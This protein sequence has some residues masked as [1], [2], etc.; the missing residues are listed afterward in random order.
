MNNFYQRRARTRI[1]FLAVL[2]LL[3]SGI[4]IL[5][6]IDLQ[7]FKHDLM[8]KRAI[9]QNQRI[10]K[11]IP[12][13]GFIY[14]RKGRILASSV[15]KDSIYFI[16][17]DGE[18]KAR[19]LR[20]IDMINQ[21]IRL[22][23]SE[24][25]KIRERINKGKSFIWIKRKVEEEK[26]R[27]VKRLNINGVYF[28]K[29]YRRFYPQRNLAS[30]VLGGVNIDEHGLNG[31]EKQYDIQLFGKE[32]T[33]LFLIDAKRRRY[34]LKILKKPIP[35]K[36][37]MLTI[38]E[39]IQ[40]IAEKELENT[41]KKFEA[42][43]GWLIIMNPWTGEILAMANYPSYDPNSYP[44]NPSLERNNSIAYIY[45]PGSTF[46]II[47]VAAAL[48]EDIVNERDVFDCEN[49]RIFLAG[50]K[51]EDYK[52]FSLLTLPEI[53]YY[54]SNVGAIKVGLRLGKEKLYKYLKSFGFGE[55]TGIDLPGEENGILRDIR[56]WSSISVGEISIGYEIGV[57]AI[58][59]LRAVSAIA[60]GGYL[61]TPRIVKKIIS[62]N[63]EESI[64]LI[65]P[66]KILIKD[67]A[68]KMT[69]FMEGVVEFGTGK[70]AKIIGYKI[71][72]K[73]GTTQK[74][75]DLK[76]YSSDSHI[77]SFV[78]FVPADEPVFSMIV[79]INEPKGEY[80][81][82]EVAAPCFREVAK[83]ILRY[84]KIF[85]KNDGRKILKYAI[86]MNGIL[87]DET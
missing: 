34:Q 87:N 60:N 22:S 71:A 51:I 84:M 77:S 7:I 9:N 5:R 13:R 27:E 78:G 52:R 14:D 44:T 16:P 79:V 19:Q 56:K 32:G 17:P 37:I 15:L 50:I 6:L 23:D 63:G 29:E 12:K 55:R 43:S 46:K 40:Y 35:G 30:H 48:Q 65:P 49:G 74:L 18:S 38:D 28:E 39:I 11:I 61:V 47:S 70:K 24:L 10:V 64:S 72:G 58:Q 83:K 3:W 42:K 41:V 31:V 59:M 75:N 57:T 4:I 68:R 33:A 62:D 53:V 36:S 76:K 25:K 69:Q 67:V 54:S 2:F 8:K 20:K 80:Y 45:E 81:G 66:R 21:I 1:Y 85:P 73:T 86:K 82:G 26:A